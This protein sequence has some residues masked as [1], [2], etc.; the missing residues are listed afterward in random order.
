MYGISP[1]LK[2]FRRFTT[3]LK[4]LFL[5][6]VLSARTIIVNIQFASDSVLKNSTVLKSLLLITLI[7]GSTSATLAQNCQPDFSVVKNRSVRSIAENSDTVFQFTL[8]NDSAAAQSY[9][10]EVI[11]MDNSC[12]VENESR[13]S[14]NRNSDKIVFEFY[15]NGGRGDQLSV[16]AF[17]QTRVELKASA[18]RGLIANDWSCFRV[19]ARNSNCDQTNTSEQVISVYARSSNEG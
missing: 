2:R 15:R 12:P 3:S 5:Q 14:S 8:N 9:V 1:S 16:P 4:T 17:S 19:I 6:V 13:A 11:P 10:L 18:L 7:L